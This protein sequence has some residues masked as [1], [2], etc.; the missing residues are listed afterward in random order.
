MP[1]KIITTMNQLIRADLTAAEINGAARP[2]VA[3]ALPKLSGQKALLHGMVW[4]ALVNPADRANTILVIALQKGLI[5]SQNTLFPNEENASQMMF[6][7]FQDGSAGTDLCDSW[8]PAKPLP[9]P[10]GDSYALFIEFAPRAAF[11][12]GASLSMTVFGEIVSD[13]SDDFTVNL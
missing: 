10:S 7:Y 13:V 5:V 9:L 1:S 6:Q 8:F 3:F 4:S 2:F 12:N 11:A